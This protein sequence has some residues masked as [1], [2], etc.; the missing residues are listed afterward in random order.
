MGNTSLLLGYKLKVAEAEDLV[1]KPVDL[2]FFLRPPVDTGEVPLPNGAV[3]K[4]VDAEIGDSGPPGTPDGGPPIAVCRS[5]I[6]PW[7]SG[8][9]GR[10]IRTT[11]TVTSGPGTVTV[12]CWGQLP[13]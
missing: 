4:R 9:E 1:M 10:N 5:Q 7:K 8:C 2:H 12:T 13:P 6:R 3:G 11:V